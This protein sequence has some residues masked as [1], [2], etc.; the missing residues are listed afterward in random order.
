MAT[1]KMLKKDLELLVAQLQAELAEV[2]A[3]RDE[4][5]ARLEKAKGFSAPSAKKSWRSKSKPLAC[6]S[7]LPRPPHSAVC[8]LEALGGRRQRTLASLLSHA[9][10]EVASCGSRPA[11]VTKR[12]SALQRR[13]SWK[14]CIRMLRDCAATR[15]WRRASMQLRTTKHC[16]NTAPPTEHLDAMGVSRTPV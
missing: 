12:R 8:G 2:K 13:K 15:G 5:L 10:F 9:S 11:P 16:F 3:Q 14:R 7:K 6:S 4:A 1:A